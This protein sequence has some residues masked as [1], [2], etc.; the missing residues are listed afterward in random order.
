M[1]RQLLWFTDT[2]FLWYLTKKNVTLNGPN[3]TASSWSVSA[4]AASLKF[5]LWS[6]SQTGQLWNIQGVLTNVQV[7]GINWN[8]V[9]NIAESLGLEWLSVGGGVSTNTSFFPSSVKP[10][11]PF[12]SQHYNLFHKNKKWSPLS[13]TLTLL[14]KRLNHLWFMLCFFVSWKINYMDI[15]RYIFKSLEKNKMRRNCTWMHSSFKPLLGRAPPVEKRHHTTWEKIG[16]LHFSPLLCCCEI[17]EAFERFQP[18]CKCWRA[19]SLADKH[20]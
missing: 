17:L 8:V 14:L 11:P 18:W 5:S 20:R 10:R 3:L 4:Q 7:N 2:W 1:F 6:H 9:L 16:H 15:C 13:V 12:I 19:A